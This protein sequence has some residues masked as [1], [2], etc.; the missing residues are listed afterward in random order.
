MK[1]YT[2]ILLVFSILSGFSTGDAL[3]TKSAGS[4]TPVKKEIPSLKK[5]IDVKKNAF[6]VG[7]VVDSIKLGNVTHRILDKDLDLFVAKLNKYGD[8]VW[9]NKIQ[10]SLL[11]SNLKL[12]DLGLASA[13]DEKENFYVS[14]TIV[15]NDLGNPVFNTTKLKGL[16]GLFIAKYDSNGEI[17]WVKYLNN[18]GFMDAA[19][20]SIIIDNSGFVFLTGILNKNTVIGTTKLTSEE[21]KNVFI[22]KL[23]SDGVVEWIRQ[24]NNVSAAVEQTKFVQNKK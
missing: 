14:G 8:V 20:K 21:N 24:P 11:Q 16:G 22:A 6:I 2:T 5:S 17:I 10:G 12:K 23:N 15:A 9:S 7:S 3:K 18:E 4:K 19:A 1:I 13:I